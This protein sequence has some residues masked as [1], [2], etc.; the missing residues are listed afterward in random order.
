MAALG[1]P[2]GSVRAIIVF[3]LLG[4]TTYLSIKGL[5]TPEWLVTLVTAAVM[6]YFGSR[7]LDSQGS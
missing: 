7:K 4:L 3:Y 1:L 2:K 5:T 6:F